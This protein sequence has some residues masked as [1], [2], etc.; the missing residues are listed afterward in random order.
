M[1]ATQ[2]AAL[3]LIVAH[4]PISCANLGDS[5]WGI[6]SNKRSSNC[7]CPFA[8]PAGKVVKG[9]VKLGFVERS[10]QPNEHRTLYAATRTGVR[11]STR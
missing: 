3:K 8:R 4:G 9:L 11:V 6:N 2:L 1:T 7:S 5:L 10:R